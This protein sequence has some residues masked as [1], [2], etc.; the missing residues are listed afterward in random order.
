MSTKNVLATHVTGGAGASYQWGSILAY[1]M[2]LGR[3]EANSRFASNIDFAGVVNLGAVNYSDF[4]NTQLEYNYTDFTS[5][6]DRSEL[7]LK[8]SISISKNTALRFDFSYND[9][10]D[11]RY[12]EYSVNFRQHF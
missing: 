11:I 3:I 12:K 9:N 4:G 10:S 2:G 7:M 6:Y 1:A 8:Q 5:A